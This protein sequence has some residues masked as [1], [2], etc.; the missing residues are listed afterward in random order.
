MEK[1]YP[2]F[3]LFRHWRF[4]PNNGW[5]VISIFILFCFSTLKVNAQVEPEYE[6]ITIFFQVQNIGAIE[7]PALI[8]GQE[9]L[10]P[11][12]DIFKFLKIK[13]SL[14][15]GMDSVSGFF[16]SPEATY[17][18]DHSKNKIVFQ[19]KS[20]SLKTGDQIRT[21][22]NL[23]LLSK[24]FGEIFGLDC[25]FNFRTL[26][27]N[28]TTKLE[29]PVIREMRLEQMRQN[30]SQL[31]GESKVDMVVP[32]SHPAFHFGMADWSVVST[33]EF[34]L[35]ADTRFNLALGSNIAGGEANAYLNYN[36]NE[37]FA[38]KQ[39]YYYWRFVN[40]NLNYLRQSTFGKIATEAI[41]SIYNPV[42]GIKLTNTPTTYRRSFGTYPLSDYTSPGWMVE[43]YVNNVLVDY[44]K[45]DA[46]GFFSFQVPLVYGNSAIKLKFYGPW[47]EERSKEQQIIVPFNFLP[48]KEFEYTMSAGMVED[49]MRSV[50]SR[51]SMN[52]GVSRAVT[53]GTGVEYLSSVATGTTMPF[54]S[55][56]TRPFSSMLLSGEYVY[57]VRGKGILSYQTPNNFQVELNYTKYKPGQKAVNFNYLEERKAVLTL[58]FRGRNFSFYNR[59]T[60]NQ[61]ILPGTGYST[62]E[63]LISGAVLGVSANL[64]N[65]AMFVKNSNPYIYSNLS[66]SFRLPRG[67]Q[68]IPQAQYE[69]S[70]HE[71]ISVK[72]GVEK[73]LF[74]NG[75]FSLSY[76]NNFKSN[77][78][79]LQ[80]GFRYDLPFAQTGLT[81]RQTNSQTTLME[82]ARGSL[83][84]DQKSKYIGA[85]NRMSVGKGGIV[86]VPFLD[87]NC[88][89]KRDKG[90]PKA[91]GLNIR[92]SGGNATENVSDTTVRVMDLEPYT[93]YYVELDANSFDNVAWKI[94]NKRLNIVV[95]PN[96]FKLVEI[97]VAVVGEVSGTVFK[98]KG[99]NQEGMGRIIVNIFDLKSQLTGK[100][101]SEQDGYYNYL[102]LAPGDYEVK[103][104]TTQLRKL[105]LLST[106]EKQTINI[107]KTR[108]GDIVEGIDF[109]LKS[110]LPEV[111]DSTSEEALKKVI[112]AQ[113]PVEKSVEKI[114]EKPIEKTVEQPVGKSIE[115]TVEQLAEKPTVVPQ[116]PLASQSVS[117]ETDQLFLQVGAFKSKSN[118][119]RMA[120][121]L[122]AVI[123]YPVGVAQE[124]G[125]Y[126]VRFGAFTNKKEAELCKKEIVD[127]GILT[128]NQIREI[129][130]L[131]N[132]NIQPQTDRPVPQSTPAKLPINEQNDISKPGKTVTN[133]ISTHQDVISKTDKILKK[134][135]FVQIGAF[136]DTKNATRLY[137]SINKLIPYPLG[138]VYRDQF[139]KVRYGPFETQGE[140]ENCIRLVVKTGISTKELL[141]IDYEEIGST[142]AADQPQLLDGYHIQVGNF[143]DKANA[144][145]YFKKMSAK[146]PFPLLMIEE[147]GHYKVRFGPFKTLPEA[148]KYRK[149]LEKEGV[150]CFMRSNAV[151]YF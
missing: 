28:L 82:M 90:E 95:D 16:L 13:V 71:L 101:L 100:T 7:I 88:N 20:V 1:T 113:K 25:K 128:E 40:N 37:P 17:L 66:F 93:K 98:G 109:T 126:K 123:H 4:L 97:P 39:Q 74:K 65:Y 44:K 89:N 45:A 12:T 130:H 11:I 22:T 148:I 35:K 21:E 111:I 70:Q 52:Y 6:E 10:L 23:Y 55:L 141:K 19:G 99:G 146:Y 75:F 125:W 27:V 106:P 77:I 64:T 137:K 129:N 124:D 83:V 43:L 31:K 53:I 50:V 114:T 62:A 138:I 86:F 104:D 72:A 29:L 56:A 67:F 3:C 135:Y 30:I 78:Q 151:K 47:G 60:Y 68:V 33:Q 144:I 122:S 14:S 145:L 115:K 73:Y 92:I 51:I 48:P 105:H 9:V 84:V 2:G 38:E 15:Q 41:S 79:S 91:K 147:E 85:N 139:Y 63:W 149:I 117:H 118:A 120:A 8:R 127:N 150:D 54:I 32:R 76:E 134:H 46:S 143:T 80:V 49:S 61:I 96:M 142:P 24:Y 34:G 136:I 103:I 133:K 102:G 107:K 121:T 18:I 131:K 36:T 110:T 58:P 94:K 119:Q 87:L 112:A 116:Q 108:D 26:S 132:G 81:V 140:L 5:A 59:M 69:Y 42:V 57:G